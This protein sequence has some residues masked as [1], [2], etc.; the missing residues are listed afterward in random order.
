MATK[1]RS[2][3][4]YISKVGFYDVRA[5]DIIVKVGG[6]ESNKTKVSNTTY[7][8]FHAKNEVSAGHKSKGDAVTK[9]TELL[10][11]KFCEVYNI[12]QC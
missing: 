5:K 1:S 7:S 3:G 12:K 10:G 4:R 11:D 6:R 9:A 2:K 8:V